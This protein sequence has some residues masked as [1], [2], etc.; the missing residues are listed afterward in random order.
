MHLYFNGPR[1]VFL[2]IAAVRPYLPIDISY[3]S[4][5]EE[6]PRIL[7]VKF[8]DGYEQRSMD[9]INA[10]PLKFNVVFSNRREIV[11]QHV[12][13]F[14]AGHPVHYPRT[15]NEYFYF[16]PPSPFTPE[17]NSPLKFKCEKWSTT[18]LQFNNFSVSAEFEQVFEV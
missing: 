13:L 11:A 15:P 4:A 6:A 3:G 12:R 7:K 5:I 2:Q 9:G 16:L 17:D 1:S 14:L 8:G 18:S 10:S